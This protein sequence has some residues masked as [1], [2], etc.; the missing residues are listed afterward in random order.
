[1]LPCWAQPQPVGRSSKKLP[2]VRRDGILYYPATMMPSSASLA[3]DPGTN[4]V[5]INGI[6]APFRHIVYEGM[7]YVPF[8]PRGR[9]SS[10]LARYLKNKRH[11]LQ[12][13]TPGAHPEGM[14]PYDDFFEA[15]N[16]EA[17]NV[18]VAQQGPRPEAEFEI[19]DLDHHSSGPLPA[20]LRPGALP[21]MQVK[22]LPGFLPRPGTEEAVAA[23]QGTGHHGSNGSGGVPDQVNTMGGRP[24]PE[25]GQ[26]V[27]LNPYANT[28]PS[29]NSTGGLTSQPGPSA[30]RPTTPR[31][32]PAQNHVYG[33]KVVSSRYRKEN[34]GRELVSL[35][36]E[37]KNLSYK[38]QDDPGNFILRD[39][40]GRRV[41]PLTEA[42][43]SPLAAGE[44]RRLSLEFQVQAK[45]ATLELEGALPLKLE[46]R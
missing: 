41:A 30:A 31:F 42:A 1:M 26:T 18:A 43:V 9:G 32:K 16:T 44:S 38:L 35:V 22:P 33:V 40:E 11:G 34:D 5:Y 45:V 3:Y 27:Q 15:L 6:R 4:L 19:I 20:H 12:Q 39:V 46:N 36:V 2:L 28:Q 13:H 7:V 21:P 29:N 23:N 10:Q 24:Q 17:P 25:P 37:Q 14:T 8:D